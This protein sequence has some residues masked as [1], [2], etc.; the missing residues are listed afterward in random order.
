MLIVDGDN[1]DDL[2]IGENTQGPLNYYRNNGNGTYTRRTG[3]ANPF[4]HLFISSTRPTFVDIDGDNDDD[5]S[6]RKL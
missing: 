2:V 3:S 5:F 4:D 6:S 1:D